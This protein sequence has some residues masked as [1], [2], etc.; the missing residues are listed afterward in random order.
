VFQLTVYCIT[1]LDVE[2]I[3]QV[4]ALAGQTDRKPSQR[5]GGKPK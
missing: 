5:A 4:F 3:L 1:A 2:M